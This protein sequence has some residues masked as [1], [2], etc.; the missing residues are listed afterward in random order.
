M[1]K[2]FY[3]DLLVWQKSVS[4]I[5]EVYAE[6]DKLPKSEEY[7]LKQQL[8]RA[9]VSV[10]LNIA[11]GKNR[12][13]AKDFMNF[14]NISSGSLIEIEAIL[15]ICEELGFLHNLEDLLSHIEE[16][17]KMINSLIA[18]IQHKEEK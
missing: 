17:A 18:S 12:R 7:N 3:R 9:V 14:L 2:N 8:K 13:T 10:S 16:L 6:A 15:L 4:L 5:K 1:T 11:E